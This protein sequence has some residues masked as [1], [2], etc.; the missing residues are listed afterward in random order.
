VN[1]YAKFRCVSLRIKKALVTD[2]KNN[3]KKKTTT[4]NNQSSVWGPA[5]WVQNGKAERQT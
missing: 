4:N 3:K 2:F 1:V 5:S